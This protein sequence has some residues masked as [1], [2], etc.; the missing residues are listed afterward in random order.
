MAKV[1]KFKYNGPEGTIQTNT[2][3]CFVSGAFQVPNDRIINV[4]SASLLKE[5]RASQDFDEILDQEDPSP[6]PPPPEPVTADEPVAAPTPAAKPKRR[7][8]AAK[9]VTKK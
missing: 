1:V 6:P 2:T 8:A 5:L 3:I 4:S 7:K 9:K